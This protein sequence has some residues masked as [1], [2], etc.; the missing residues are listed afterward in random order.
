VVIL[1]LIS[2]KKATDPGNRSL[3]NRFLE[4]HKKGKK[5]TELFDME[6][7]EGSEDLLQSLT[8]LAIKCLDLEVDQRPTMSEVAEQLV[9]FIRSRQM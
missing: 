8:E 3:V 7:S 4:N 9:A 2:R 5:S 1:E 6:I